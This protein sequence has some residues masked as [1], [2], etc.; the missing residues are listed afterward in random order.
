MYWIVGKWATTAVFVRE[1]RQP[2]HTTK[3][4]AECAAWVL[5]NLG[6][7][8]YSVIRVQPGIIEVGC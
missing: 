3:S 1:E 8:T 7:G 4:Q 5:A 2:D 6:P